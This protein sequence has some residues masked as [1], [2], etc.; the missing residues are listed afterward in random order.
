MRY[1]TALENLSVALE[2]VASELERPG[3]V[4]E[5]AR[6]V[7]PVKAGASFPKTLGE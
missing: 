6:Q 7:G 4:S 1:L 2:M 3:V 5:V